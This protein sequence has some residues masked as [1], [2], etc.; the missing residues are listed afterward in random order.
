MASER[1]ADA[2]PDDWRLSSSRR[3]KEKSERCYLAAK[4]EEMKGPKYY[5]V[6]GA[7]D[8]NIKTSE[9]EMEM[10][11]DCYYFYN[12]CKNNNKKN[13]FQNLFLATAS[14]FQPEF[15]LMIVCGI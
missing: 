13:T 3:K 15:L 11:N 14:Y 10:E 1:R 6:G 8:T 5:F 7:E 4:G 2:A 9:M 12:C